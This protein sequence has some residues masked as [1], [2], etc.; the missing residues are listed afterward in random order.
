MI[1]SYQLIT[2]QGARPGLFAFNRNGK[3]G[4]YAEF[5]NFTVDEPCADRSGNIPFGKSVRFINLAT[6]RPMYA[7]PHGLMHDAPADTDNAQTRFTVE[8]RGNGK[9]AVRSGDGRY[10]FTAGFGLAGDLRLTEDPAKAEEFLW[11][12]YLNHEFMLMSLRN[13]RYAGKDPRSGSSYSVDF[14]GA[15]PAR[16]NGAVLRWEE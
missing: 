1:L 4:G 3:R 10:P 13:N 11:Q 15:D 5:D 16:R 7:M 9:V 12:D 2:F 6:G 8:D 14:P